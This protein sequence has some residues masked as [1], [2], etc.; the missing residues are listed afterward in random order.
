MVDVNKQDIKQNEQYN[1]LKKM[2]K[3]A[4]ALKRLLKYATLSPDIDHKVFLE[5][6][7]ESNQS[8]LQLNN[9]DSPTAVDYKQNESIELSRE[10]KQIDLVIKVNSTNEVVE[11]IVEVEKPIYIDKVVEVEKIVEVEKPV[12][13]DKIV[14]VEKEVFVDKIVEVEKEVFV[15]K[16]VEVE[17]EVYI[18][19]SEPKIIE[20]EKIVE[21]EKPVYIE[22]V[23]EVE[24]IVEVEKPIYVD[25][26]VE[27]IIEVEKEVQK[28]IFKTQVIEVQKEPS[29][30]G[31][32]VKYRKLKKTGM[33]E[34]GWKIFNLVNKTQEN[35]IETNKQY[36]LEMIEK[37]KI[38]EQR[39]LERIK[40][41][42]EKLAQAK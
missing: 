24:K 37:E 15:D 13:V 16:V 14:E 10:H 38:R 6:F 26:I 12:Y 9:Y 25:K 7:D 18:N 2:S 34:A 22:K 1:N 41:Q 40:K 36:E 31:K 21:V 27:K 5:Q 35:V 8:D 23:V 30:N 20:V 4:S 19:N 28:P 39:R 29:H 3:S 32:Y 17:K 11:R 42:E 33:T